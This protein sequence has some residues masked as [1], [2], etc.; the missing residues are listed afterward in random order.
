MQSNC[1]TRTKVQSACFFPVCRTSSCSSDQGTAQSAGAMAVG[2]RS[3]GASLGSRKGTTKAGDDVTKAALFI[4][5]GL[6]LSVQPMNLLNR[7]VLSDV[8]SA[9]TLRAENVPAVRPLYI[10]QGDRHT[11]RLR[12]RNAPLVLVVD[13]PRYR[14]FAHA[15]SLPGSVSWN[16]FVIGHTLPQRPKPDTS[17]P[18]R[19]APS[20]VARTRSCA[21][22]ASACW[23]SI[24]RMPVQASELR[25]RS[26]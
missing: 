11:K 19:L 4:A 17:Y 24:A 14:C 3:F 9:P 21:V 20:F 1:T 26:G 16:C 8:V 18:S 5:I 15:H 7:S 10:G 23:P 22:P 12:A 25:A 13:G 2:A 6:S